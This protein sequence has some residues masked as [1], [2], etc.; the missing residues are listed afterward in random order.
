M[1]FW[2]IYV[3]DA[4]NFLP[5]QG[6]WF[7]WVNY[8][9]EDGMGWYY[10]DVYGTDGSYEVEA[11]GYIPFAGYVYDTTEVGLRPAPPP[12]PPPPSGGGWL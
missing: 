11:D 5:I 2:A 9:Y 6:A 12:P 10:I 3:Y 7:D 1:D 8:Y 4:D